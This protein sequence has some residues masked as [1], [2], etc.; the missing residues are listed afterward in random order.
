VLQDKY[1]G[2]I[3]EQIIEDFVYYADV[4]YKHFGDRVS[5]WMTFNEPWI[6]CALSVSW[7]L[8]AQ[9]TDSHMTVIARSHTYNS[10]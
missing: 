9:E 8:N 10:T 5:D 1:E 4:L 7:I 2:F 6:T 3:G